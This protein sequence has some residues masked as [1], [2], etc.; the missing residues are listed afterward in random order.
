MALN[1]CNN[2]SLSAITA[3]PSSI[4]GG[5][6]TLISTQTASSSATLSFTSGI[7]STYKKYI[8]KFIN[9]HP[10]TNNAYL[11][12]QASI[13]GGSNYNVATTSTIFSAYHD[14]ADT[15]TALGYNTSRDA[16]QS[17]SFIPLQ[18]DGVSN[19]ND[20]SSVGVFHLFDPSNTT[21][22]KHFFHAD[23][24]MAQTTAYS[25]NAYASG[26]INTTSAVNA[27]QFKFHSGNIDSGVIKLYGVS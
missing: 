2:N 26:Y 9:L 12:F 27:M 16:V 15:A 1:F 13:D 14:E 25:S 11:T 17:T 3:I 23:Q 18:V 19:N 20:G 21:F 10:A 24:N 5:A 6:L 4:S 22:V 7:D 8:F